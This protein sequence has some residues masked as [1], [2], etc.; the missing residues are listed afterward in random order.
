MVLN[1]TK[2]IRCWVHL[3]GIWEGF[4]SL[5]GYKSLAYVIERGNAL[6]ILGGLKN[7]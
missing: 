4:Y 1:E 6:S 3:E 2:C 5:M 7:C